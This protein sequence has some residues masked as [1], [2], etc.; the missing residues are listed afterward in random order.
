MEEEGA[1][2]VVAVAEANMKTIKQDIAIE[3]QALGICADATDIKTKLGIG[4]RPEIAIA[5]EKRQDL[6]FVEIIAE[7]YIKQDH[8]PQALIN[9]RN[10][11]VEII[12]HCVSL[13]PGGAERPDKKRIERIDKLAKQCNAKLI[14]DHIC[15][16]RASGIESGHLLPVPHSQST[17]RVISENI[18]FIKEHL[19]VPFALE[20]IASFCRWQ[21]VEMDEASFVAAILERTDCKLLLDVANLFANSVNHGFDPK[22]YLKKLPL[23][24]LAY[25]H[26]A[27]G[28]FDN[29]F[30]HDTHAH[31]IVESVYELLEILCEMTNVPAVMLERDDHFPTQEALNNELDRIT[32]CTLSRTTNKEV[33]HACK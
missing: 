27:G 11:G 4:W 3:G 24:R 9:L 32:T 6:Q 26:V 22:E 33:H 2:V 17:V 28:K 21:N 12:P 1:A 5:I 19:S 31:P 13:N 7:S 15:F 8:I 25:V 10:Q 18:K 23:E 20:N 30:Y 14:S 29:S 16:V